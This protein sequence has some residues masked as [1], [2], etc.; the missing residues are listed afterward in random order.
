[1]L[2]SSREFVQARWV[3]TSPFACTVLY[4]HMQTTKDGCLLQPFVLSSSTI[5]LV[6]SWRLPEILYDPCKCLKGCRKA[7]LALVRIASPSISHLAAR[8]GCVVQRQVRSRSSAGNFY[9]KYLLAGIPEPSHVPSSTAIGCFTG[10]LSSLWLHS[11][12]I[13]WSAVGVR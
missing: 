5:R 2:Q 1:M 13:R 8:R 6:L 11:P 9:I 4:R 12:S 7:S 10:F 3:A